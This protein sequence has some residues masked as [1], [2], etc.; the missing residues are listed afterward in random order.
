MLPRA[1]RANTICRIFELALEFSEQ[2]FPIPC[3]P[4]AFD[5]SPGANI[6]VSFRAI[7][8]DPDSHG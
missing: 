4:V 2:N 7:I 1:I 8:A 5:N 6:G 3:S